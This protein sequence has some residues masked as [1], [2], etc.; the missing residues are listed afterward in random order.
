MIF[1]DSYLQ[2]PQAFRGTFI[3]DDREQKFHY[4]SVSNMLGESLDDT[5]SFFHVSVG[6]GV[7]MCTFVIPKRAK[8]IPRVISLIR[9]QRQLCLRSWKGED[10]KETLPQSMRKGH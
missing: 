9:E 10:S 8:K 6:L 1:F 5:L 3:C 4:R 7:N 2:N